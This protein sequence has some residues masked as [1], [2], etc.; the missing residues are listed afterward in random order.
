MCFVTVGDHRQATVR[1]IP[2]SLLLGA[3]R[4][5]QVPTSLGCVGVSLAQVCV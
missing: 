5:T 4:H 3:R 1:G 2:W